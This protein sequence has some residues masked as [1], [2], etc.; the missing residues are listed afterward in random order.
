MSRIKNNIKQKENIEI[1]HIRCKQLFI[2]NTD[3]KT[4]EEQSKHLMKLQ[5]T[6]DAI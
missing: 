4:N 3:S 2:R 6:M 1:K 5:V